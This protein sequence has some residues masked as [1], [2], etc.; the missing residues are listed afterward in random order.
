MSKLTE[1]PEKE[2]SLRY[3]MEYFGYYLIYDF[4]YNKNL[5]N[6]LHLLASLGPMHFDIW[7]ESNGE[8]NGLDFITGYGYTIK[9]FDG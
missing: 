9:N 2:N 1:I 5:G 7:T 6:S 4:H 8:K 3:K